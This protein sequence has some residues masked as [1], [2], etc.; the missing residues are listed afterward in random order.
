MLDAMDVTESCLKM[1]RSREDDDDDLIRAAVARTL[2]RWKS[3]S[4]ARA[5]LM[6]MLGKEVRR[7][8]SSFVHALNEDLMR[9]T[10]T[11]Q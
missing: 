10:D 3:R 8:H 9:G 5:A 7:G 4:D 2:G 6:G 11:E 1:V